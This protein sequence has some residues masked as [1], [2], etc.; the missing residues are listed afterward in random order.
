MGPVLHIP[1]TGAPVR[2][3]A[4][5]SNP[6]SWGVA[7]N[8]FDQWQLLSLSYCFRGYPQNHAYYSSLQT[9][10]TY[11]HLQLMC[12]Q[13]WKRFPN[14]MRKCFHHI[15]LPLHRGTKCPTCRPICGHLQQMSEVFCCAMDTKSV[16]PQVC[17]DVSSVLE[18]KP[19]SS[20]LNAE[21]LL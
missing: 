3:V 6:A 2:N 21:P 8:F 14:G 20:S 12:G 9:S 16:P 19:P 13:F 7:R 4:M 18:K 10:G 1:F 5:L 11:C 15:A 17:E